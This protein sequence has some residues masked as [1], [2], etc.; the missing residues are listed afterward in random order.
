MTTDALAESLALMLENPRIAE[1]LRRVQRYIY[2][3]DRL[4][5]RIVM[6]ARDWSA[7]IAECERIERIIEK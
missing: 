7:M 5:A 2:E 6:D 1:E 3:A 4:G